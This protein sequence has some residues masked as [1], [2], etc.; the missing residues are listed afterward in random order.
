MIQK[1]ERTSKMDALVS[2]IESFIKLLLQLR[3]KEFLQKLLCAV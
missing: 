2:F 3:R 1:K